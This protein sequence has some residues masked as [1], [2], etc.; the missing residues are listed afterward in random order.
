MNCS[1]KV[2]RKLVNFFHKV[3]NSLSFTLVKAFTT[4]GP[5]LESQSEQNC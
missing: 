4:E 3:L 1:L 2:L 5:S